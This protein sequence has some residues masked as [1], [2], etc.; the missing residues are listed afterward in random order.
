VKTSSATQSSYGHILK[1]IS[2]FGGVKVFEIIISIIRSKFVAILLGPTGMGI[3][4]LLTSTTGLVSSITGLGLNTSAVR[5]VSVAHAS[6][7][8]SRISIVI[9]VLRKLVWITGL[10]GAI[11]VFFLSPFLSRFTFKSD[12]YSLAFKIISITLLFEQLR[13]GQSVLLQGTRQYSF[14]A[15]AS[16]FGNMLGLMVTVPLYYLYG[17]K[18]IVPVIVFTSSVSLLISWYFSNKV[19]IKTVNITIKQLFTE[20]R[21]MVKMGIAIAFTGLV[22]IGAT[23]IIRIFIG[24][25]GDFADVGLYTAGMTLVSTYVGVILSAM[26]TDYLPRL[27][28]VSHN[29]ILMKETINQQ[30]EIVLLLIGPIIVIFLVYIRWVIILLYSHKFTP[31][32]L[33]IQWSAIGMLFRSTSW[34]ISY[35]FVAK[36]DSKLFFWNEL[37]A[38]IVIVLTHCAGYYYWKLTGLGIAFLIAYIIYLVQLCL[39]SYRKYGYKFSSEFIRIFVIQIFMCVSTFL[40]V[41]LLN[42]DVIKLVIGAFILFFSLFYSFR[43][44]NKRIN[45]IGL[46]N[47]FKSGTKK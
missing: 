47:D 28:G 45:L 35:A 19:S 8:H 10:I 13:I 36:G 11:A 43:E 31:I 46:L 4:G 39:L 22:T 23:Y 15:K 32:C 12:E 26:A 44:L 25:V 42:G 20:S 29:R 5:D 37:I 17:F 1:A 27:A 40:V 14:L 21:D 3:V 41:N 30:G 16:I 33:M 24:R 7:E 6:G 18:G 34:M 38:N 9:T 2:L